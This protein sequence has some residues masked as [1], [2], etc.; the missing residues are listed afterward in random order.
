MFVYQKF[1]PAQFWENQV[2]PEIKN[3][4]TFGIRVWKVDFPPF[5]CKDKIFTISCI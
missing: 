4:D 1:A 5:V 3:P 2:E